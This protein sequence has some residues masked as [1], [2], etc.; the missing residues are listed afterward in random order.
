MDNT[1]LKDAAG[2]FELIGKDS[3]EVGEWVTLKFRFVVVTRSLKEKGVL[4]IGIPRDSWSEPLVSLPRY[5]P[6]LSGKQRVYAPFKRVNTTA[7]LKTSGHARAYLT[8]FRAMM[9]SDAMS[10]WTFS[11]KTNW[12]YWI[13]VKIE[14]GPLTGGDEIC[15]VYGDRRFGEKGARVQCVPKKNVGFTAYVDYDG[16]GNFIEHTDSPVQRT[17]NTGK[18]AKTRAVVPSIVKPGEQFAVNISVTDACGNRPSGGFSGELKARIPSL[19]WTGDLKFDDKS[20]FHKKLDCPVLRE[21]DIALVTVGGDLPHARSNPTLCTSQGHRIF[22]GDLHV[23]SMHFDYDEKTGF[24]MKDDEPR[25]C[26]EYAKEVSFLDFVAV[27]DSNPS[28]MW[29]KE[30]QAAANEAYKAGTFVT[31]RGYEFA[32]PPAGHRHVI[33]S[34]GEIEPPLP[35]DIDP[36]NPPE[37]QGYYRGRKDV[38]MI[39]HHTKAFMNWGTH[40]PEL[41]PVAEVYS[42]WGSSEEPGS[43]LWEKLSLP[44]GSVQEALLYGHR[45]GMVAGGDIEPFPG[46]CSPGT[47][48]GLAPFSGGLTAVFAEELTRESVFEAIRSRRC[49]ATTGARI[50]LSFLVSETSMGQVLTPAS[51]DD[52]RIITVKVIGT[53]RIACAEIV[54]NGEVLASSD[55]DSEIVDWT[56][57]DNTNSTA[58]DFYY[59]RLRQ[60]DGNR[61]WSSPVWTDIS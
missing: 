43:E 49:Y 20:P 39:P 55:S 7:V 44:G 34:G 10:T 40:D 41:E 3:F 27:T 14:G 36:H 1:A 47:T 13:D 28:R 59:L 24:S 51:Q 46:R 57:K 6:E 25:Q 60:V 54:K 12:R 22:W 37:L 16:N 23:H 18:A 26:Y 4:R 45:P 33:F 31:F 5:W 30:N 32:P 38:L 21:K 56:F 61:A 48:M 35:S 11:D 19:N 58:G 50:I 17:V 2:T 53:D 52:P 15:V 9:P 29:W 42:S 8:S